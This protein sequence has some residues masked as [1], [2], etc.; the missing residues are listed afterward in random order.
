[1]H[2]FS[3]LPFTMQGLSGSLFLVVVAGGS[4]LVVRDLFEKTGFKLH[5]LRK[6][7]G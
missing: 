2:L 7:G 3:G 5:V 4:S 1:M 6:H